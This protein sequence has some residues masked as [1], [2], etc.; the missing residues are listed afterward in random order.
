MLGFDSGVGLPG[1]GTCWFA[2]T[3]REGVGRGTSAV[4]R[5]LLAFEFWLASV[6]VLALRFAS[7]VNVSSA[8][9]LAFAFTFTFEL[10]A[11]L[12]AAPPDGIP[13]SPL[14]V[15]GGEGCTAWLF[16]SATSPG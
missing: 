6:F 8:F 12:V 4:D 11:G 2:F 3:C 7:G 10:A 5:L 1:G 16:G 13:T 14:P 9:T 15:A